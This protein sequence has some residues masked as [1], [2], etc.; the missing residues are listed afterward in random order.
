MTMR[1]GDYDYE[2]VTMTMRGGDYD[3]ANPSR[4]AAPP[5]GRLPRCKAARRRPL[6]PTTEMCTH[7]RGQC[8]AKQKDG[9]LDI[10]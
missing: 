10:N 5:I 1:G 3:Y 8:G 7:F 9:E 6:S 4:A 2:A